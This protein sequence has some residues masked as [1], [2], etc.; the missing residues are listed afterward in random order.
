[1]ESGEA[2]EVKEECMED[3]R[4]ETPISVEVDGCEYRGLKG[5]RG[6]L[7]IQAR[8]TYTLRMVG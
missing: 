5:G 7:Y 8:S 4:E 6:M 2:V 1:V 3:S